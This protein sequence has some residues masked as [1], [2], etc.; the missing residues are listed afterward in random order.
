MTRPMSEEE[1]ARKVEE[2]RRLVE[3]FGKSIACIMYDE[4]DVEWARAL[5]ST[6][7][8]E[9]G[10]RE[11]LMKMGFGLL[12]DDEQVGWRGASPS[13]NDLFQCEFCG[14]EHRDSTLIEHEANC[15]VLLA[16]AALSPK[17]EG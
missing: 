4:S 13:S 2:A 11:A 1:R 5:L 7:A 16:R 3:N 14:R 12:R 8:S 9:R 15:P 10:M 6:S 17:G